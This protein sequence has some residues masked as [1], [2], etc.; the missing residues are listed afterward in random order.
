MPQS[1]S[2]R[3]FV[4]PLLVRSASLCATAAHTAPETDLRALAQQTAAAA[5]HPARPRADRIRQQGHRGLGESPNARCR[6]KQL[7]APVEDPA[8]TDV[9][10]L[11][12]TPEKIGPA[13][14]ARLQGT[15]SENHADAHMDT[16][17]SRHAEG[18]TFRVDGDKAYGLG[19]A[20]DKQGIAT[21]I[22][23]V[24]LLQAQFQELRHADGADQRRRGNLLA[25]RRSAITRVAAEQD[26]VF[27][28][29]AMPTA[30]PPR[31]QRHR[32]GLSHRAW[33][34]RMQVRGP[35]AA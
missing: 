8:T 18:P 16:V 6:A 14:Q 5:R 1:Y 35:K 25:R 24:A 27:V 3:S 4:R 21:I 29:G 13:V 31:H 10:R 28:R 9:Y 17:Y 20:D 22:H 2:T 23:A 15:G 34:R 32:L 30:P 7:A 26:A 33:R 12:D 11:D 19:I